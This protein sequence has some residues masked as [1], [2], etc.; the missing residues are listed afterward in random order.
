VS[1][2]PPE[3]EFETRAIQVQHGTHAARLESAAGLKLCL[4]QLREEALSHGFTHTALHL[5]IAI[6][7]LDDTLV[8]AKAHTKNQQSK[9][10]HGK[11]K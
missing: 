4:T 7:E 9:S 11:K 1:S 6:M 8:L 3:D 10:Q 2:I 5:R